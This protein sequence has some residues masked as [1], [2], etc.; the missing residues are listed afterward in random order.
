MKLLTLLICDRSIYGLLGK[1]GREK[2]WRILY[3]FLSTK[4]FVITVFKYRKVERIVQ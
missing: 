2:G 4:H 3:T 1:R